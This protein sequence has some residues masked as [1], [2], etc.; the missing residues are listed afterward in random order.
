MYSEELWLGGTVDAVAE[1]KGKK[2]VVDFKTQAKMW[3]RTPFL[4]IAAY[5]LLLEEMGETGYDGGL[6]VLLPKTGGLETH[7]TYK[8]E[9]DKKAFLAALTL[10]KAIKIK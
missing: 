1:I 9:E 3:D 5:R 7:Y 10:Y 8:Y 6:I 2:Y 4:Q